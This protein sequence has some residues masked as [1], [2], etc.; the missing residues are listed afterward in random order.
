MIQDGTDPR[1][2][3]CVYADYASQFAEIPASEL[4]ENQGSKPTSKNKRATDVHTE[5]TAAV[6]GIG[7]GTSTGAAADG[8]RKSR[9]SSPAAKSGGK[10]KG[11]S[12]KNSKKRK[13]QVLLPS[14]LCFAV[15]IIL[16]NIALTPVPVGTV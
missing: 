16:T 14:L 1:T 9:P 5:R 12:G 3:N 2:G 4:A 10:G 11:A 7:G 15:L 8:K 13:T 6:L